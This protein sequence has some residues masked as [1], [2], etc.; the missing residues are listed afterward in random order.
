MVEIGWNTEKH[1]PTEAFGKWMGSKLPPLNSPF[2]WLR[3][4]TLYR[5]LWTSKWEPWWTLSNDSTALEN[6]TK[7]VQEKP[8]RTKLNDISQKQDAASE[9][10]KIS[11]EVADATSK[12]LQ[13]GMPFLNRVIQAK[14]E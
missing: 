12:L 6:V 3:L 4:P 14:N 13:Y 8:L 1:I 5:N 10:M 7:K 2:G 11:K 9:K